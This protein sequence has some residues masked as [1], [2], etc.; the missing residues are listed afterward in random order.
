MPHSS[1]IGVSY[2][3]LFS[4]FENIDLK[5]VTINH[6]SKPIFLFFVRWK[7]WKHG[8]M[9]NQRALLYAHVKM[10]TAT[11]EKIKNNGENTTAVS[12]HVLKVKWN[13]SQSGVHCQSAPSQRK[14]QD[15]AVLCAERNSSGDCMHDLNIE[16]K[17]QEVKHMRTAGASVTNRLAN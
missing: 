14:C 17:C 6:T 5:L 13:A 16:E 15:S 3:I 10:T 8:L 1:L 7:V 11:I 12:A 2:G 4:N 9:S